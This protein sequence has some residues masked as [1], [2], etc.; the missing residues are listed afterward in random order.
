MDKCDRKHLMTEIGQVLGAEPPN[1]K[2]RVSIACYHC[3]ETEQ[4]ELVKCDGTN[5]YTYCCNECIC[6]GEADWMSGSCGHYCVGCFNSMVDLRESVKETMKDHADGILN[7][8]DTLGKHFS[9]DELYEIVEIAIRKGQQDL[10]LQFYVYAKENRMHI[11]VWLL[12]KG[13]EQFAEKDE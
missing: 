4:Q 9:A 11:P 5:C 6:G 12:K 8:F 1:K 13:H 7:I 3:D 10:F 2:Q